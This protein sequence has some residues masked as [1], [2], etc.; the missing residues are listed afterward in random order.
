LRPI[1]CAHAY[2][3]PNSY[4]HADTYSDSHLHADAHRH[5]NGD[6]HTYSKPNPNADA[7]TMHRT[8][9]TDAAAAP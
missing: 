7:D 4:P 8:M 1:W 6:C 3:D 9:Y 2:A 5:S